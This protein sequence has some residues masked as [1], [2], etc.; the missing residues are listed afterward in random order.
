M[1]G[2][3]GLTCVDKAAIFP[4]ILSGR[5]RRYPA[6]PSSTPAPSTPSS[7]LLCGVMMIPREDH[8]AASLDSWQACLAS[9]LLTG[10][11]APSNATAH[12]D[13]DN[14]QITFKFDCELYPGGAL[15]RATILTGRGDTH[16]GLGRMPL[17]PSPHHSLGAGAHAPHP[18]PREQLQQLKDHLTA[19]GDKHG[20]LGDGDGGLRDNRMRMGDKRENG[21]RV[22][23][24]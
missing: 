10:G 1:C 11:R 19:T 23:D 5:P 7:S 9:S 8:L 20:Y 16:W 13:K 4:R 21:K 2:H 17:I 24:T 3:G 15:P 22:G 18:V 6:A 12:L 14:G